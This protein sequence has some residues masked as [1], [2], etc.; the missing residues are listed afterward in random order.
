SEKSITFALSHFDSPIN[1]G[2]YDKVALEPGS[3][4]ATALRFSSGINIGS[5][6]SKHNA[7]LSSHFNAE[8]FLQREWATDLK[9]YF[10]GKIVKRNDLQTVIIPGLTIGYLFVVALTNRSYLKFGIKSSLAA[11]ITKDY[12]SKDVKQF[13]KTEVS[14]AL[15]KRPL[16]TIN[17]NYG[18]ML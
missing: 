17:I 15:F 4:T 16:L 10:D 9:L 3:F 8:I 5:K 7:P 13:F 6:H 12:D 2:T 1:I 11:S 18:F 14:K